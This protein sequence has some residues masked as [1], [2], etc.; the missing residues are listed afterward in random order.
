VLSSSSQKNPSSLTVDG[1]QIVVGDD[2]PTHQ[3]TAAAL[4]IVSLKCLS[5]LCAALAAA[6]AAASL[7]PH[8]HELFQAQV[9]SAVSEKLSSSAMNRVSDL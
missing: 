3:F 8:V 2:E 5:I 7:I 1:I 4:A 9:L 6:A